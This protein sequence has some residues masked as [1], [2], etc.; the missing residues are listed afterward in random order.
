MKRRKRKKALDDSFDLFLDTITNTFGG[1]LLIA[2]LIVLMI[3]E[4]KESAPQVSSSGNSENYSVVNSQTDAL[5]AEKAKLELELDTVK[6]FEKGFETAEL[7][8]LAEDLTTQTLQNHDLESKASSLERQLA[9]TKG[10]T[11]KAESELKRFA[12]VLGQ[13]SNE[14]T[15]VTKELAKEKKQ[16]TRTMELPKEQATTKQEV[17]IFVESD[18]LFVLN[19]NRSGYGFSLNK[20]HFETCSSTDADIDASIKSQHFKIKQGSG[21]SMSSSAIQ[22]QFRQFNASRDF[23]TYV[24]RSDSFDTFGKLRDE[25]VRSGFEYRIIPT[26]GLISEG[27]GSSAKTQ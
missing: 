18:K 14:R 15:R 13:K 5:N 24:V 7:K 27:S 11:K 8:Q 25:S 19:S 6:E 12:L 23:L 1:V 2:L 4:S 16:R 21:I 17:P 9:K 10:M 22:S 20:N 26:D 3:R